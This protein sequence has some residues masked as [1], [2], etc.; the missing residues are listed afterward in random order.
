[1]RPEPLR[2]APDDSRH[3][4]FR[5][6]GGVG[7]LGNVSFARSALVDAGPSA[8][9]VARYSDGSPA[10]VDEAAGDGR[11]LLFALGP[12]QTWN[13]FPLQPAF[14]P[15]VHETLRYLASRR[16][17]HGVHR[18]RAARR[19]DGRTPGIVDLA[20][21]RV[22]VNIDPRESDPARMSADAF[23]ANVL[24]LT[25]V[26]ARQAGAQAEE[27][28]DG[29]RLWQ[30]AL[31]A[32]GGQSG[33]RGHAGTEAGVMGEHYTELSAPA[34]ARAEPLARR[35]RVASVEPGGR[36]HV[37][38]AG[39]G[40]RRAAHGC[41]RGIRAGGVVAVAVAVA[42]VSLGW[43]AVPL[44]RAPADRQVARFIEECC[45]E[46]ED[47]LVTAIAERERP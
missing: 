43:M 14:V 11:V 16:V 41:T 36:G 47:A 17:P 19:A 27:R 5:V 32:D 31:A 8:D 1:M 34:G 42:L 18:R 39:A 4:V 10:L 9:I 26:A 46:L 35:C 44:R 33:R 20:A 13:D 12:E 24:R 37:A 22:A 15:F 23:K 3:P 25:A 7:T 28:E 6:F 40:A 45:P 29:Q 2:F 21:R 38:R 30:Y